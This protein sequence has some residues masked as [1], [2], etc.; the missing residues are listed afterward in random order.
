M[1]SKSLY[2]T[3][4]RSE[5]ASI[6][7]REVIKRVG[8]RAYRYRVESYREGTK[9][10]ARW[11]YLGV[12]DPTSPETSIAGP[13]DPSLA[14]APRVATAATRARLVDAFERLIERGA[15][16]NLTAG[17]V[18]TEAGLAHGTFYRY[19]KNKR[20]IL[21][22]ALERVREAYDRVRPSFDPPYGSVAHERAR[23]RAWTMALGMKTPSRGVIAAWFEALDSDA[24]LEAA[25]AT[26]ARDRGSALADYLVALDR[27]GTIV[28]AHPAELAL[29]LT[30]LVEATFRSASAA[31]VA[32]DEAGLCGVSDLFDRAIFQ[33]ER[34]AV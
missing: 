22:A 11:T 27:A 20:E 1:T 2:H 15:Y 14:P 33:A 34:R 26:R 8:T 24:E 9:V 30:T 3:A 7:A 16:A 18:S 23:V 4:T 29:A 12:V 13:G 5:V 31:G 10:R 25:R 6:V 32:L 19:F 17:A 28:V 21:I